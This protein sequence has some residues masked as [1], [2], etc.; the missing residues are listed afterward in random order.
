MSKVLMFFYNFLGTLWGLF[1]PL[2]VYRRARKSPRLRYVLDV[3]DEWLCSG[4]ERYTPENHPWADGPMFN[5][6]IHYL[7]RMGF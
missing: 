3:F 5:S 4:C 6:P 1:C 2:W 7:R